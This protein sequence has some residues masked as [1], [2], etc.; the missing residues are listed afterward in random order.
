MEEKDK[1]A[2]KIPEETA[3]LEEK[4]L[5][6]SESR[7]GI[8]KTTM[9]T[10]SWRTWPEVTLK[11]HRV[12]SVVT[13]ADLHKCFSKHGNVTLLELDEDKEG[14]RNGNAKVRFEPPPK[15]AFWTPVNYALTYGQ[16]KRARITL[17]LFMP[18]IKFEDLT[19]SPANPKILLQTRMSIDATQMSFGSLLRENEMMIHK[20]VQD[21]VRIDMD[22]GR[23]QLTITFNM[24]KARPTPTAQTSASRNGAQEDGDEE[25]QF[26]HYRCTVAFARLTKLFRAKTEEGATT[27]IVPL[28][29]PAIFR[30]KRDQESLEEMAAGKIFWGP[31]DMWERRSIILEDRRLPSNFPVTLQTEFDD[32]DFINIGRWTTFRFIIDDTKNPLDKAL[33]ALHAYNIETIAPDH[34]QSTGHRSAVL[35]TL[36]RKSSQLANG[37]SLHLQS[38]ASSL[39]APPALDFQVHYQLEVCISRGIFCEYSIT[40]EFLNRLRALDKDRA[41]WTLE[42][43][44]DQGQRVWDPMEIFDDEEANLFFPNPMMPH[45]CSTIRKIVVTPTTAYYSSPGVE[46]SNRVLRKYSTHQDR[47]LRVQFTDELYNGKIYSDSGDELFSRVYRALAKGITIGSRH[48]EFLAFGNSQIRECAVYFFCP[49][50]HLSCDQIR[51]WMGQFSHI[52][53][54][55]KYAARIGQCFSTTRE[56]R[57][58]TIPKIVPIEDIEKNGFCFSDGVGKIS[59]LLAKMVV[60]EMSD[61]DFNIAPS[62]FQFRMGGCKG[63][64]TVW[65]DAK[66]L[67]VHIR[68]SQEKFKATF[69]GLEII[70]YARHSIATL[71]RQTIT[72]LTSL[73]VRGE[74][75]LKLAESQIQNY[76]KAMNDRVA[77]ASLLGQYID[78]NLT[79][80]TIKD[81]V[82]WGF[83][84]PEI[85]E[86][87]VLTILD[88]WR[89]WSMKLLKE[90]AR[91]IIEQSA[92]LLGCLDETG[93]LCG[94]YTAN[95]GKK[96]KKVED[97]PQIFLQV[98][99][100]SGSGKF[101]CITGLCV[102]G[103]N[104]SLHPGDIRVVEAVDVPVLH[105][106]RNVVVFPSTGDRDV[107]S[108]MSGGDLDG[109]DFFVIWDP[110]LIP[111]DWHQ[112]PM[113]YSQP[114]PPVLRRDVQVKDLRTFFV[115][116]MQNDSLALIATA[117]LAHA[118]K[119]AH[120]VKDRKCLQLAAL[121]SKA[122]DYVKTGDPAK[123]PPHLNPKD[124]PH[125][126]G[127]R[128][129]VYHSSTALG[130]LY[131]MIQ[132]VGF[133]PLY[134]KKFDNR[135]LDR[136]ELS[137]D[138]LSKAR[139]IKVQY[140]TAMRRLMG[141]RDIDTEFEIWT[142]FALSK[143]RV[144]SDYKQ[145]EE[146]GRESSMLKQRFRDICYTEAGGRTFEDIAPFV[147]AMYKVTQIEVNAALAEEYEDEEHKR[148][149]MP[150]IT[151]PWIF[152]WIMGRIATGKVKTKPTI[153]PE[154][155]A[156]TTMKIHAFRRA[157]DEAE[158]ATQIEGGGE[159]HRGDEVKIFASPTDDNDGDDVS[160][161]SKYEDATGGEEVHVEDEDNAMDLFDK[162]MGGAMD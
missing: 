79:S 132:D 48:Y 57:G 156:P 10:E 117:H 153:D 109:D 147:A 4:R 76:Q 7:A 104:P 35:A 56:I 128:G 100:P 40:L 54:V 42:Y 74:T 154:A 106:L 101:T 122:V 26:H 155:A 97:L 15:T 108:M 129:R 95:E 19:E 32:P 20:T 37:L 2:V 50:D 47:F 157:D 85:Q 41:K 141:Q 93:A 82:A 61:E 136:F 55:A 102:I 58:V 84:D 148:Q 158:P 16:G 65:P 134:E 131:D 49:T 5:A 88:L 51:D 90:K 116:Y 66:N 130:K 144:G 71:N 25:D 89:I 118:D 91:V 62:A 145:Q 92:F 39:D 94:Y 119:S 120:G 110:D 114:A 87:F 28:E 22:L 63:M 77:A 53:N 125:F 127:G 146:I 160:V 64:L 59:Q 139:A 3:K 52:K 69:N 45:Y 133:K 149:S 67:E 30:T 13:L 142:G 1:D 18:K 103:R 9:E 159:V 83:M 43:F 107:P 6:V 33:E 12:P 161:S 68:P 8:K 143:P 73:G 162:L 115:R 29:L 151:F 75:I 38:L 14:N 46:S 135:V 126:L 80:L 34:F 112:P 78:E 123:L 81:L 98:E 137:D 27:L 121:H 21:N 140:D 31:L 150:L 111:D 124:R 44:A 60:Q 86:P 23:K 24:R 11:I 113:N 105:H 72:V 96:T 70:K 138:L 99:S 36:Y 17:A 152:H